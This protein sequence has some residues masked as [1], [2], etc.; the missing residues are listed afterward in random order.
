MLPID[1]KNKIALVTG[2]SGHLGQVIAKT[3]ANSGA[4][5]AVHFHRNEAAAQIL[6]ESISALG[7]RCFN[8]QADITDFTSVKKMRD[9]INQNLGAPDIV[10]GNA[11]IQYEPWKE[12]LE[13]DPSVYEHQFR[14]SVMQGVYLAKAFAPAMIQK[15]WGRIIGINSE[16]S[17]QGFSGQS[18]YVSG[19][20]GMDGVMRVLAREV[21][22]HQIT[23]NQVA[24]G[25]IADEST[26]KKFLKTT[27]SYAEGVPLKR[28]GTAQETAN[29]V[30]FLASDLAS[31]VTGATIPVCGGNVLVGL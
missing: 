28:R 4:D 17:V 22:S 20:L 21:G 19:K 10:V 2:A 8:V 1:L 27:D 5:V 12:V 3:L 14:S 30:A 13:E 26:K 23:V 24:P 18:G 11:V 15:K 7:V 9:L 16:C 31:Y 6:Q 29:V 25:T